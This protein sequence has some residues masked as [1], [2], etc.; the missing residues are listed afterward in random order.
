MSGEKG[1]DNQKCYQ[2]FFMDVRLKVVSNFHKRIQ[3]SSVGS[4][5]EE[6]KLEQYFDGA[7]F[8][9]PDFKLHNDFN[10]FQSFY[11]HVALV[12]I[13]KPTFDCRHSSL[14]LPLLHLISLPRMCVNFAMRIFLI[15]LLC[16]GLI[17]I[18]WQKMNYIGRIAV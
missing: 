10:P 6:S 7:I 3:H 13:G 4:S 8:C 2:D 14:D 11:H 12:I 5:R 18:L 16:V 9:Q 15:R 1:R 17:I